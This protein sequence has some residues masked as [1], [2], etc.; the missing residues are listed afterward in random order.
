MR[1]TRCRVPKVKDKGTK[2]EGEG[3]A[4]VW[5][6]GGVGG[7]V[8]DARVIREKPLVQFLWHKRSNFNTT[9]S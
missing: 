3:K 2:V 4:K 7:Q 9:R 6:D 8:P 1:Q 5:S